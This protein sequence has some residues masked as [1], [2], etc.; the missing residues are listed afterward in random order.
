MKKRGPVRRFRR[1]HR[2]APL[3]RSERWIVSGEPRTE[4]YPRGSFP[5]RFTVL[6]SR[7]TFY[8]KMLS[9][10]MGKTFVYVWSFG[11]LFQLIFLTLLFWESRRTR[12]RIYL[13]ENWRDLPV[14]NAIKQETPILMINGP[15]LTDIHNPRYQSVD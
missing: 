4:R 11:E 3:E 6:S 5:P 10:Q 13:T 12:S 7:K 15:Q 2:L 1:L 14:S 9:A 8:P